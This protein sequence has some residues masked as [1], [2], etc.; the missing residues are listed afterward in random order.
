MTSRGFLSKLFTYSEACE[1]GEV[2]AFVFAF[3]FV[4]VSLLNFS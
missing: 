4:F 1:S 3:L 2:L